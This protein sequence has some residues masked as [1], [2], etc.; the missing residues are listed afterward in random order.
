MSRH[1]VGFRKGERLF[2]V[3]TQERNDL[4]RA[5]FML[6]EADKLGC[7]QFVTPADVVSG[8]PKLNLAF[9]ANLFNTYPC[10]HKPDSSDIDMNL[11][12]GTSLRSPRAVRIASWG[13]PSAVRHGGLRWELPLLCVGTCVRD[14][15]QV[16]ASA[17][18]FG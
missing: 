5:G 10:L 6:Q 2:A 9:V 16:T 18:G 7:R 1:H 3:A 8:N 11:L 13:P 14:R 17:C 15:A 4:K 12:E